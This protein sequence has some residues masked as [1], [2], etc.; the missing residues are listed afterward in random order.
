MNSSIRT[1][2]LVTPEAEPFCRKGGLGNVC[3]ELAA[4]LC[5]AGVSTHVVTGW[6]NSLWSNPPASVRADVACSVRIGFA[7]HELAVFHADHRGVRYHFLSIPQLI[8][9]AYEGQSQFDYALALAEG[10]FRA[11]D[12]MNHLG[13][14]E[15]PQILH[16]HDWP[17][18]LV[19]VFLRTK[20]NGH[21][22]LQGT[23]SV[24]TIHNARHLGGWIPGHRF[25]ELGIGAEHWKSFEQ[26][27]EPDKFCLLR[28]GVLFAH[29]LNAVSPTNREEMLTPFGGFGLE[30]DYQARAGDLVGIMNGISYEEWPAV[31]PEEKAAAKAFLQKQFGFECKRRIPLFGMVARIDRQKSV[32]QVVAVMC[33]LLQKTSGGVQFVYLGEG[34]PTD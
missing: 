34:H 31:T 10:T 22:A 17:T 7:D 14:I 29:K 3:G 27:H 18:A 30:R 4:A 33:R 23:A 19:P 8:T 28:G 15:Q 25:H 26:P 20:Y 2:V 11:I 24:L 32:K 9:E 12:V 6:Y 21:P 13:L 1:V 16:A 5:R